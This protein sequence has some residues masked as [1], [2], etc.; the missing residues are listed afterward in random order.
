MRF[1]L[2]LFLALVWLPAGGQA[3][4]VDGWSQLKIGMTTEEA[5]T[6]LG[7]PLQRNI[8]RGFELWTY[9]HQAEVLFYGDLIG[10]T[11]PGEGAAPRQSTDVWKLNR[12]SDDFLA[13]LRRLPPPRSQPAKP[14]PAA[15]SPANPAWRPTLRFRV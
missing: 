10:W 5:V 15:P 8:G 12:G 2:P 11:T 13:V 9:D 4:V 7:A 3:S 1:A 14:R 6:A